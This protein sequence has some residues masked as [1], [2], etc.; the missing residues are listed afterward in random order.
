MMTLVDSHYWQAVLTNDCL[1]CSDN[2]TIYTVDWLIQGAFSIH[3]LCMIFSAC[4]CLNNVALEF[5]NR[6]KKTQCPVGS[7]TP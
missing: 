4:D 7:T 1:D 6:Q 3:P 2:L 5:E